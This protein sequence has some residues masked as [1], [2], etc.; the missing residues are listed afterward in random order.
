MADEF[1][2]QPTAAYV[3]RWIARIILIAWAL[4]WLY[5]YAGL[6]A[7][8]FEATGLNGALVPLIVLV[9]IV[10]ALV[11]AWLLELFGALIFIA[12]AVFAWFQWEQPHWFSL[13]TICL[14]MLLAGLLLIIA[15]AIA[16]F[17]GGAA[18]APAIAPPEEKPPADDSRWDDPGW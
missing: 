14:P 5:F 4:I 3:L 12:A 13:A 16:R 7:A 8:A 10:F 17:G 1:S 11:V 9:A 15:W 18:A 6:A 2:A